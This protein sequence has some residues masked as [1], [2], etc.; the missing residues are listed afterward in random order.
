M[1]FWNLLF[2]VLLDLCKDI[3]SILHDFIFYDHKYYD[4]LRLDIHN[5][6][7]VNFPF[8][9]IMNVRTQRAITCKYLDVLESED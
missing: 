2:Q 3:K 4:I 9:D 8:K 7:C 1:N 5:K 6:F